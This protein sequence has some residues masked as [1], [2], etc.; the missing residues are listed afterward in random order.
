MYFEE[1]NYSIGGDFTN[2]GEVTIWDDVSSISFNADY[3]QGSTGTLALKVWGNGSDEYCRL[4]VGD[5]AELGGVLEIDFIKEYSPQPGD[6]FEIMTCGSR[7]GTFSSIVSNLPEITFE[8]TYTDTGLT[9]TVNDGTA[10]GGYLCKVDDVGYDTLDGALEA[11]MYG[12]TI[13]LLGNIDYD[14]GLV[15]DRADI[16][17]DLNGYTLNVNSSTYSVPGVG[18]EVK[19]GG[20]VYLTGSGSLMSDR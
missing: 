5:E 16:I 13:Q 7:A 15:I 1:G 4:V 2:N 20:N 8:P 3:K 19:N 10:S 17:F 14:G 18:L 6:T 12:G 11:V 9:L